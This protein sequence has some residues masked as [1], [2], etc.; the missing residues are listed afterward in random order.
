MDPRHPHH[1]FD[2]HDPRHPSKNFTVPCHTRQILTHAT[3]EH[4]QPC[5]H[6]T[7]ATHT[8]FLTHPTH[9]KIWQINA[10]HA[11]AWPMSPA[12][13]PTHAPTYSRYPHHLCHPRH[14]HQNFTDTRH[15]CHTRSHGLTP[16]HTHATHANHKTTSPTLFSRLD[17]EALLHKNN[18]IS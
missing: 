1:F 6:A 16:P 10:T 3:R 15:P 14:L 11:K 5:T 7:D 9:V 18:D 2:P 8:I 17:F 13:P 12:N 4:T